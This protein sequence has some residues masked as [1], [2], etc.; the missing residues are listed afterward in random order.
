MSLCHVYSD[1][2]SEITPKKAG[3]KVCLN[4]QRVSKINV[5][6]NTNTMNGGDEAA[7]M[8]VD[9]YVMFYKQLSTVVKQY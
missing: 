3:V 9:S 7:T 5:W 8:V 1:I 6:T 2:T 4:V